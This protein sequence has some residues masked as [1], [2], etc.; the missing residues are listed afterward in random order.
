H[1]IGAFCR[2]IYNKKLN[3][4]ELNLEDI[5]LFIKDVEVN[6][7]DK[8]ALKSI[9][10]EIFFDEHGNMNTFHPKLLNYINMPKSDYNASL[11]KFLYDVLL[12]DEEGNKV[13]EK[14]K[15]CFDYKPDNVIE[16]LIL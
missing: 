11:A 14:I 5:D 4:E 3:N 9:I 6:S 2:L 15:D 1:C 10:K 7:S 12:N 16:L 13:K 8:I